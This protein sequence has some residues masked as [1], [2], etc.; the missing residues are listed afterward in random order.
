M[1]AP[2]LLVW[3]VLLLGGPVATAAAAAATAAFFPSAFRGTI[4]RLAL[5]YGSQRLLLLLPRRP[6][7]LLLAILRFAFA[8]LFLVAVASLAAAVVCILARA[9][10][11]FVAFVA[12]ATSLRTTVPMVPA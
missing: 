3:I 4:A 6:L 9:F 12:V 7:L 11:L 1:V 5:L 10:A 2:C 8:T